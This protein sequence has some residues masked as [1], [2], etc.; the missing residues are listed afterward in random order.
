MDSGAINHITS[1]LNNLS[2][3]SPYHGGDKITIGNGKQLPFTH[4]GTGMLNT[5]SNSFLCIPNIFHVPSIHKN[6]LS[7]SQVTR[8][9][10]V[11]AE[12]H[13]N[14]CLI[15]DKRFGEVLLWGH[16]RMNYIG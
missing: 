15:K 9:H 6:L 16:L 14:V 11:V 1:I 8:D 13:S 5:I 4:V 7:V 12:F 10:H 3:H 2:L